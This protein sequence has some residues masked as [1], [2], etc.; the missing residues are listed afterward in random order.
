MTKSF[1]VCRD[2]TSLQ[3][4]NVLDQCPLLVS[5]CRISNSLLE[6]LHNAK[7]FVFM[8]SVVCSI[9]WRCFWKMHAAILNGRHKH[10]KVFEGSRWHSIRPNILWVDNRVIQ[11]C[12][13]LNMLLGR[14]VWVLNVVL[15][16]LTHV[17][18]GITK[19]SLR[20]EVHGTYWSPKQAQCA[21][22]DS[23]Q[24]MESF[25]CSVLV[26]VSAGCATFAIRISPCGLNQ[27]KLAYSEISITSIETLR[28]SEESS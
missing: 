16:D 7:Q 26:Q 11:G 10:G 3:R 9:W 14:Q 25:L 6:T 19:R 22:R 23:C 8:V 4:V 2:S 24:F 13:D 5:C 27:R 21:L 18:I 1:F 17:M 20:I 28:R 12:L 15:T